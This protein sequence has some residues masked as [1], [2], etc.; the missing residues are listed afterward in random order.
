VERLRLKLENELK[1]EL[2]IDALP[3]GICS[4]AFLPMLQVCAFANVDFV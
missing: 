2:S 3:E 4:P 1:K